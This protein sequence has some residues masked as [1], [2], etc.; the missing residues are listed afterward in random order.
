MKRKPADPPRQGTDAKHTGI[1]LGADAE[2]KKG[3][4]PTSDRQPVNNSADYGRAT[5]RFV[6][7][8]ALSIRG[9]ISG[10]T[11]RFSKGSSVLVD[12]RDAPFLMFVPS[13]RRI[14]P[15]L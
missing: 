5:F 13:L 1:F 6:G 11:Y 3:D 7:A 9:P 8:T 2:H 4:Q 12:A 14:Q 15:E 10:Q